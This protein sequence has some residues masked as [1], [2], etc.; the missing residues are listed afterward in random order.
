MCWHW[1]CE[2]SGELQESTRWSEC[3]LCDGTEGTVKRGLQH[4][5]PVPDRIRLE[6]S[7]L[8][9][10]IKAKA[11][12]RG[13]ERLGEGCQI[14]VYGEIL[15]SEVIVCWRENT[16][17]CKLASEK[18]KTSQMIIKRSWQKTLVGKVF[19]AKPEDLR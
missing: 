9:I 3:F 10:K 5:V 11:I 13:R 7:F 16:Q 4:R 19:V 8:A 17:T 14:K 6:H 12:R 15:T 18:N 2:Q 1:R